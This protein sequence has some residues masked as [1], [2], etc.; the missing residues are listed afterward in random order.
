M[1]FALDGQQ[2]QIQALLRRVA[3]EKVVPRADE[4]DRT[5][6]YPDDMFELLRE[7]GLFAV[8]FPQSHGGTGSTH[9]ACVVVEELA[10]LAAMARC[11]AS[12]VAMK[13][14]AD[15]V[16]LF[17]AAGI[18]ADFPIGR[19]MRDAKA[20]RIVEGTNQI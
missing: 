11:Y 20:L 15:A 12:D 17:G 4:I 18:S 13:V 14:T 9:S 3:R 1:S 7:L 2:L 5:A 6:V 10:T 16:Q 8:P 19:Y